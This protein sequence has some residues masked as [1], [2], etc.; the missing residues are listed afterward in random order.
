[1]NS[2]IH[3]LCR[4]LDNNLADS[5]I[6]QLFLRVITHLDIRNQDIGITTALRIPFR[7]PVANDAQANSNRTYFLTHD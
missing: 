7:G 1:M 6:G 4:T 5:C 3:A 2:D